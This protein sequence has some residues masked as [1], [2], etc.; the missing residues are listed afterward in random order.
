[1]NRRNLLTFFGLGAGATLAPVAAIAVAVVDKKIP[2]SN[3]IPGSLS[4]TGYKERTSEQKTKS[5]F[6]TC[7]LVPNGKMVSMKVS[8][9]GHLWLKINNE[10]KR[11]VTE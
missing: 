7:D 8:E 1:M 3:D 6:R 2:P 9:D 4:I 5:Y 10:W 11:I